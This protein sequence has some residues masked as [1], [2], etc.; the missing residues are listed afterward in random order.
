VKDWPVETFIA[1]L[2]KIKAEALR[3][4]GA[5][6]GEF[7][8]GQAEHEAC[9]REYAHMEA[10]F[11]EAIRRLRETAMTVIDLDDYGQT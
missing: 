6:E 8:V 11:D 1:E 7:A 5:V 3:A 10:V 2:V 9:A 4:L